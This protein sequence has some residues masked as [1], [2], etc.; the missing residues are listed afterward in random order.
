M[1]LINII[2]SDLLI[3]DCYLEKGTNDISVL[4]KER[5]IIS[6]IDFKFYKLKFLYK[7]LDGIN[8]YSL[9]KKGD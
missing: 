3:T 4:K 2:T 1:K 9:I 5:F 8:N 6:Y 7:H